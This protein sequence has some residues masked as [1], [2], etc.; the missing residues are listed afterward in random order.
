MQRSLTIIGYFNCLIDHVL[1]KDL[2]CSLYD[3][4]HFN[5]E[6]YNAFSKRLFYVE[7]EI[8]LDSKSTSI[9]EDRDDSVNPRLQDR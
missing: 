5:L 3:T 7:V 2:H 8:I 1:Y 9:S 6:D 4:N